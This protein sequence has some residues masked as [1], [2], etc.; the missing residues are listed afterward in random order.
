M[1]IQKCW[2]CSCN[3]YPGHGV[4]FVR[5][6]A[7]IFRFCSS[8][9][10]KL[11]KKRLNPRKLKWTKI[12]R[13]ARNKELVRDPVLGFERRIHEP[14]IYS[15]A[16]VAA[17][18]DAIPRILAMRTER[19]ALFTRA[20]ILAAKEEQKGRDLE[21]IKRYERLLSKG[22]NKA[23]EAVVENKKKERKVEYN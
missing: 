9:C 4:S 16:V 8:K 17:A 6:D 21:F 2:F 3:I 5:N 14:M 18:V 1:R 15:R 23:I 19:E 7:S 13:V 10:Y 12:S 22:D 20:R 11:F